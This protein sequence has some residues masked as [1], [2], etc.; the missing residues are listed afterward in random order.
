VNKQDVESGFSNEENLTVNILKPGEQM[1]LNGGFSQGTNSWSWAVSGGAAAQ[2]QITNEVSYFDIANGGSTV[3]SLQLSQPGKP[4]IQ[5][6]KYVFEF[7][8]WAQAPRYIEAKVAQ[9]AS[10]N[11]SYSGT[12]FPALTPVPTRFRKVFTMQAASDSNASV[13]FNLGTSGFDVYLDNVSLFSLAP[14][15]LNQ[16]GCVDYQDLQLM[17]T[18]WLKSQSGLSSDLDGD[19]QVDFADFRI[20]GN[21]WTGAGP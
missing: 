6:N 2:W 7:D 5:G 18:D 10:P 1:M 14:G 3:S 8:A 4:L 19:G 17:T 9:T 15:D 12:W 21:Y 13:M 11:A 20:L 16:D